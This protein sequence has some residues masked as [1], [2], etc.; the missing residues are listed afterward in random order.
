MINAEIMENELAITS[1]LYIYSHLKWF[2]AN[3]IEHTIIIIIL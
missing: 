2:L 1:A 3:H